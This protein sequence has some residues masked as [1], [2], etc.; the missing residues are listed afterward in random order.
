M[1]DRQRSSHDHTT[2]DR[3][4]HRLRSK[5]TLVAVAVVQHAGQVL[6]GRRAGGTFLGGYWEFP[7]GKVHADETAREAARR[8]CAEETGLEIHIGELLCEVLHRYSAGR[9]RLW[10]YRAAPVDPARSP[11][12]P[13]RWVPLA[14]L[15]QYEMPPANHRVLSLLTGSGR[16]APTQ[17]GSQ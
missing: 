14:E 3:S 17:N 4:R 10:F 15:D 5:E 16:D 9:F 6:I 7:G 12:E 8:E 1:V 2:S 11:R 13:F